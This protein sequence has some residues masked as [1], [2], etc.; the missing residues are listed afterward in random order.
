MSLYTF[1]YEGLHLEQFIAR[2]HEVGVETV[3]DV[4]QLPLSRKRGFSKR[5]FASE[6][7]ARGINYVHV[8]LLGCPKSIRDAYKNNQDWA[9]YVCA[10]ETYLKTQTVELRELAK[11]ARTT[12]ACLVCFE[13]D[14]NQCHRTFVARATRRFGAPDILHINQQTTIADFPLRAAA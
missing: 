6:L 5:G 14:Y 13:A 12:S 11:L 9:A 1:G 3:V 2:M 10:F 4:R 7:A 8:P